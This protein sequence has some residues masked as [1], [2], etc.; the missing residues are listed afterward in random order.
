MQIA[1]FGMKVFGL[2]AHPLVVHAAVVMVPLSA[3]AF[4]ATG[5]RSS[6][7]SLYQLPIT[8]LAGVGALAA[9]LATQTGET[10]EETVRRSGKLVGD[11]PDQ[12]ETA[13]IVAFVFAAE[14][15]LLLFWQH[16]GIAIRQ[17]LGWTK[18]PGLND[19]TVLYLLGLPIAVLAVITMVLAGHSGANLVWKSI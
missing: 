8:L 17:R 15:L 12:G 14:C 13:M 19:E 16:F 5:W 7:R 11:H 4:A 9:L 1:D 10:L 6:L 3:V 2:P 18:R